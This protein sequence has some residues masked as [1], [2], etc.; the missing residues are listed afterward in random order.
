MT[1]RPIGPRFTFCGVQLFPGSVQ[2]LVN[3]EHRSTR[4]LVAYSDRHPVRIEYTGSLLAE[5][6]RQIRQMEVAA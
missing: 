6:K 2:L 5:L 4:T 3:D 1:R